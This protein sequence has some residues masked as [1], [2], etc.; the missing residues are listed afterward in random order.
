MIPLITPLCPSLIDN[1]ILSFHREASSVTSSYISCPF[2]FQS[3]CGSMS[4]REGAFCRDTTIRKAH[5][6]KLGQIRTCL[7]PSFHRKPV[8]RPSP[9]TFLPRRPLLP[10]PSS[11]LPPPSSVFISCYAQLL[12]KQQL[13]AY[14]LT[15]RSSE[16]DSIAIPCLFPLR[17]SPVSSLSSF[18][19]PSLPRPSFV[20]RVFFFF[21]CRDSSSNL[22]TCNLSICSTYTKLPC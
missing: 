5:T 15:V 21:F 12:V 18:G 22:S 17:W 10:P 2:P 4:R 1:T 8:R 9:R 13:F 6:T 3:A 14:L 19:I 7:P 16:L 11:R 20:L